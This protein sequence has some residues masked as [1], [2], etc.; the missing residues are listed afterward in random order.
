MTVITTSHKVA[1]NS[2][3][4][5]SGGNDTWIFSEEKMAHI[6]SNWANSLPQYED[7][8]AVIPPPIAEIP[9][10]SGCYSTGVSIK[11]SSI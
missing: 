7:A 10:V 2:R 8:T 4:G 3:F 5:S 6:T 9:E 1:S 11:Y